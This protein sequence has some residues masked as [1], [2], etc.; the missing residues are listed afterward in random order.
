MKILT[1]YI[2]PFGVILTFIGTLIAIYYTRKNSKSTKYI[3]T[4]TSERI[5][6]IEK[7][8]LETAD[9]NSIFLTIIK[10]HH[11]IIQLEEI[12]GKTNNNEVSDIE[13]RINEFHLS[14]NK[15]RQKAQ[16]QNEITNFSK[17]DILRKI[18]TIRLR[19]N[20]VEDEKILECLDDLLTFVLGQERTK[21]SIKK[22]WET[23]LTFIS[24]TQKMLKEEWEKVKIEARS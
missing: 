22:V 7:I 3:D 9:L 24:L 10:N 18:N 23:N 16:L 6:W 15:N 1:D 2:V 17:T 4:V 19:L 21:G 20:P 13:E 11:F 12:D 5:K 14:A 8:R